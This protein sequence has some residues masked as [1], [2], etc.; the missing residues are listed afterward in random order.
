MVESHGVGSE[1]PDNSQIIACW[2]RAPHRLV[3]FLQHI[4]RGQTRALARQ[5]GISD[6]AHGFTS[7][8]VHLAWRRGG[9]CPARTQT[10]GA[11][12]AGSTSGLRRFLQI[13]S[14]LLLREGIRLAS[15]PVP[16][17][18]GASCGSE[19]AVD[20]VQ[21][22]ALVI[23]VLL[24]L[25][26]C[27]FALVFAEPPVASTNI[28]QTHLATPAWELDQSKEGYCRRQCQSKAPA[29]AHVSSHV[30]RIGRA[31]V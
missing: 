20:R 3:T 23:H 11:A 22:S 4:L 2:R 28:R 1:I 12:T 29:A 6:T 13:A 25:P 27:R 18:S 5:R 24:H 30:R 19:D 21:V 10:R 9:R 31:H 14:T 17:C 26:A 7:V 15:W 8:V 16:A